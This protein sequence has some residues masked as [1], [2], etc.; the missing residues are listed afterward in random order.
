MLGLPPGA[1]RAEVRAA[2]L[3]GAAATH[4]DKCAAPGA[5]AAFVR[6]RAAYDALASV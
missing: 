4:P 2:Y 1:G 6:L 5:A 3:A